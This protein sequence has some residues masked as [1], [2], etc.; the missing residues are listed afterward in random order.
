VSY[1]AETWNPVTGTW[2][3]GPSQVQPRLYH[4]SAI[5]LPDGSVLVGGGGAPG[6]VTNLN[7]QTYYPPYLF[8]AGGVLAQRPLISAAPSALAVG[9]AFTVDFGNAAAISRVVLIKTGS[10]THGWNMEQRF[11]EL[12]FRAAGARLTVQMTSHATDATPGRY[13]L[14]IIDNA[15]VPSIGKIVYLGIAS[16]N[17]ANAP[18]ITNPGKQTTLQGTAVNLQISAS[19]PNGNVLTY[20][21][22]ALPRGLAIN[23]TSGRITGTASAPGSHSAVVAASDGVNTATANL[24]WIVNRTTG[25]GTGLTGRYYNNKTLTDPV[26]L[27]RFEAIDYVWS[28]AP[29]SGINADGFSTRWTGFV[30]APVTGSYRFQTLS[31]D[32]IRVWV[33]GVQLI[34]N[35]TNHGATSNTSATIALTGATKYPITVEYYENVGNS[36]ARLLWQLPGNSAFVAVPL[37]RLYQN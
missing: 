10:V 29:A 30:Q 21:A 14:F 24:T 5:L 15:G 28:A 4:S 11:I 37:D 27:T 19:D 2:T 33:N 13:L 20:S 6:P 23:S 35:W 22:A 26:V 9:K 1:N 8:A 12:P 3:I 31:D 7:V 36:V 25:S 34:N 32:G 16:P 17:A 18:T